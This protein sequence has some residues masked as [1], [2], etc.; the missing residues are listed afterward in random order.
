MRLLTPS[1]NTCSS[2]ES[3]VPCRAIPC[4]NVPTAPLAYF[5]RT[6]A[7]QP[8]PRMLYIS[9]P[10]R[11]MIDSPRRGGEPGEP[12]LLGD[13]ALVDLDLRQ[14][15][16][17]VVPFDGGRR[18]GVDIDVSAEVARQITWT[19]GRVETMMRWTT[20]WVW[21]KSLSPNATHR[22]GCPAQ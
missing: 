9:R 6:S 16:R 7:L 1:A 19:S 18:Q 8:D 20:M 14:V 3:F 21:Q 2:I 17:L 13:L 12:I 11:D 5:L 10:R 15:S 4:M 22:R